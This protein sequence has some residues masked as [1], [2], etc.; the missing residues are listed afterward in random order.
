MSN[1]QPRSY[2]Q[3]QYQSYPDST[4]YG[5]AGG[6]GEVTHH[7]DEDEG[8]EAVGRFQG[9]E[10]Q[11]EEDEEAQEQEYEQEE[12]DAGSEPVEQ[13]EEEQGYNAHNYRG[14]GA[15]QMAEEDD[16]EYDGGGGYQTYQGSQRW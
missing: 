14:Y 6:Y 10:D 7:Y 1:N 3:V 16:D 5:G 13:E 15:G 12:D 11:G 2:D 4:T 8:G 9:E